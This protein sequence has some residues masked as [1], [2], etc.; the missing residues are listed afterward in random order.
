[1]STSNNDDDDQ[2][3]DSGEMKSSN[4]VCTSCEQNNVNNITKGIDSVAILNDIST[5]AACGKE[6]NS[7]KMNTC[8]KCKMVKYCNA[9]CKK[10]HRTKHKKACERR[11]AEL[12][13]IELFKQPLPAEDCPICF[14]LLPTLDTGSKYQSCCGKVICSGCRY[15]P[16][17][18]NQGNKVDNKKCPFCRTPSPKS[19]EEALERMKKRIE[20][21]D[22]Q[23]MNN[24]GNCYR[25]EQHGFPQNYGKALELYRRAGELGYAAAHLNIG[26]AYD[27]FGNGESVEVNKKKAV[28]Y[29]ELAAIGGNNGA[30]YN[31]GIE[32]ENAGNIDRALKHYIIAVAGGYSKSLD[33]IK[34]LYSNGHATKEDYTKALEVYQTYLGEIKS[35]QR[36]EAAAADEEYRYY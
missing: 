32:E 28:H 24:L 36:D 25:D 26:Y 4:K 33:T 7:D 16:V 35:K 14:L 30:R 17:Y 27:E 12:H 6:N 19:I 22:A 31:L 9:A 11:V 10:K 20:A 29:Y 3:G 2:C 34:D 5:C 8:N 21:G 15:A 23:A 13:D 18:D 1:M